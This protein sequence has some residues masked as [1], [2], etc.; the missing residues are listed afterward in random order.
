MNVQAK[1]ASALEGAMLAMGRAAREAAVQLREA[2][3][4]QKNTALLQAAKAIRLH[5]GEIIAA[6]VKDIATAEARGLSPALLD[7]LRLDEKRVEAI[8]KSVAGPMG[9]TSHAWRHPLAL[10]ESSMRA[11]PM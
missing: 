7:R 10:S 1:D 5:Q 8:A 6:N 9:S 2:T 4:D 3:S 11:G